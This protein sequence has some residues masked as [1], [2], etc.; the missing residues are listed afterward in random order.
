LSVTVSSSDLL[1]VPSLDC[2]GDC[3]CGQSV[4]LHV[5]QGQEVDVACDLCGGLVVSAGSLRACFEQHR[6]NVARRVLCN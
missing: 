5:V 1:E 2:S 6:A 3:D 4:E